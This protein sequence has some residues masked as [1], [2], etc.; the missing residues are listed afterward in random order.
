MQPQLGVV[1]HRGHGSAHAQIVP[2]LDVIVHI[3]ELAGVGCGDGQVGHILPQFGDLPVVIVHRLLGFEQVI[4]GGQHPLLGGGIVQIVEQLPFLHKVAL[5]DEQ[6]QHLIPRLGGDRSRVL[7]LGGAGPLHLTHNGGAVHRGMYRLT[8]AVFIPGEDVLFQQERGTP[9]NGHSHGE[10][11]DPPDELAA[12]L[13]LLVGSGSFLVHG[14]LGLL[15]NHR[16]L[17]IRHN[18]VLLTLEVALLH[19]RPLRPIGQETKRLQILNIL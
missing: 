17:C 10:R 6:L 16:G 15:L 11:N 4:L 8:D 12:F 18:S 19:Y 5:A 3:D 14:R 2:H 7:G 1:H 9:H 13:L